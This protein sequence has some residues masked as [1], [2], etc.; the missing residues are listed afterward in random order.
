MFG[1]GTS[2]NLIKERVENWVKTG[3]ISEDQSLKIKKDLEESRKDS[4]SNRLIL[5]ISGLGA[6]LIL[7][8]MISFLTLNWD[9][10]SIFLKVGIFLFSTLLSLAL[11]YYFKYVNQN[12]QIVGTSLIFLGSLLFGGTMLQLSQYYNE[13]S[14]YH[15]VILIWLLGAFPVAYL[16]ES[17]WTARLS[18][19]LFGFWIYVF[20]S[21]V[22]LISFY[23]DSFYTYLNLYLAA[24]LFV[25]LIGYL[26]YF[27]QY[28]EIGR[29]FRIDGLMA[30]LFVLLMLS[31]FSITFEA[32]NLSSEPISPNFD[33]R[34]VIPYSLILLFNFISSIIILNKNPMKSETVGYEIYP[35]ILLNFFA[36]I[37][38]LFQFDEVYFT[39]GYVYNIA[40]ALIGLLLLFIGYSRGDLKVFNLGIISSIIYILNR[41]Y[42]WFY[43]IFDGTLFFIFGGII[44]ISLGLLVEKVRKLF[45]EKYAI[46]QA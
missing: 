38:L 28:Y 6:I 14:D 20:F 1:I 46:K 11:G 4:D 32:Q 23:Y 33:L 45:K 5:I 31:I 24:A 34:V 29:I 36:L 3:I 43:E 7:F 41:Y 39:L 25:I 10:Y 17:T 37:A 21:E 35:I 44:L 27:T 30:S 8:G 13:A 40:F 2:N 42:T 26:N 18:V 9:A 15:L 22:I 19:I 12:Y 16:F